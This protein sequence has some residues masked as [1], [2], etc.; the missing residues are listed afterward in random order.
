M[1]L[2][3]TGKPPSQ[4]IAIDCGEEKQ[5]LTDKERMISEASTG[6][7]MSWWRFN[8]IN[9]ADAVKTLANL[10][11]LVRFKQTSELHGKFKGIPGVVVSP[12]PSLT[13]NI[14]TLKKVKGR[15]L[16]IC[17]LRALGTLLE[18]DII[19]DIV[20][21]VD[22]FNLKEMQGTKNNKK[23]NLWD[24]WIEKNDLSKIKL[25]INSL[26]ADP[27]IFDIPAQS[28]M[29]MNPALPISEYLPFDLFDY[30]RNGVRSPIRHLIS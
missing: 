21:Q 18:N 10:H 16:I 23:I 20:I 27:N 8:T 7:Q 2:G 22:P 13:D 28:T 12:G 11:N 4:F 3:I 14:I 5:D 6:R 1:F 17:V 9:R 15:A 19:P 30:K 29:W 26:N 24:E 25:F